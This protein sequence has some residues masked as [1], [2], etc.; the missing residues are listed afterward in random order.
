MEHV[1]RTRLLTALVLGVVFGAGVLLG[2]AADSSL[3]AETAE[4]VAEE[5]S[6]E[7]EPERR[8]RAPIYAQVDPTT[9]Q[10]ARIEAI[11]SEHRERTNALDK[12]V[13]A[14]LRRGFREIL[15][16]TREAIKGVFTPEQAAEYQGLLDEYDARRAAERE[17]RDD[18]K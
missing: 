4:V 15:F 1:S 5:T 6:G 3:R 7:A 17:S 13:G 12:D 8:R 9:D 18:R 11:I 16:E 10:Q 2:L 14:T